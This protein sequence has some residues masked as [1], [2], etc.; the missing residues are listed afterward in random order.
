MEKRGCDVARGSDGAPLLNLPANWSGLQLGLF[1]IPGDEQRGPFSTTFPTILIAQ[2][3]RG[4]RWYRYAGRLLELH[5]APGMIEIYP[6]EHE[7]DQMRWRGETG[8]TISI[9]LTPPT[10]ARLTQRE[11][12]ADLVLAHEEFDDRLQW[13]AGELLNEANR[14][15][16]ADALYVE[17]LSIAFLGRLAQRGSVTRAVARE[18]G[19]FSPEQQRRVIELIDAE[20][21]TALSITRLAATTGMSPDHFAHRF[22]LTFGQSPHRFVQLRRIEAAR[23]LLTQTSL[24][25]AEIALSTGFSSQSHF[26]QVFRQHTG[27]TP[28]RLRSP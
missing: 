28:A 23:R 9:H 5:T 3:G 18:N 2:W 26:T 7:F 6:H 25:I 24:P 10:L 20:L 13:L 15:T 17:G 22:K 16:A 27:T 21:G 4:R 19:R 1:V 8:Q 12:P 14:G 11:R